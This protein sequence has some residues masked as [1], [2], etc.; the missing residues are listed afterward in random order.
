MNFIIAVVGDSY[1][2]CMAKREAQSYKVKVDMIFERESVMTMADTE[3]DQ[4]FPQFI[5]V[6]RPLNGDIIQMKQVEQLQDMF[7][8]INMILNKVQ[9]ID[10]K[11]KK[12]QE[13]IS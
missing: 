8:E 5:L 13:Q 7:S 2:N 1:S 3:N 6:R 10:E 12:S 11:F 4:Y 9:K